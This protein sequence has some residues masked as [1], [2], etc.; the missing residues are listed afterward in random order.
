MCCER[1]ELDGAPASSA[2]IAQQ[3]CTVL[4]VDE[5]KPKWKE[6]QDGGTVFGFP[7]PALLRR[8]ASLDP[9]TSLGS[10]PWGP[11]A[12]IESNKLNK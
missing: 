6:I 5:K 2:W 3:P 11:K 8:V 4:N 7:S 12:S 10:E 1:L 9:D